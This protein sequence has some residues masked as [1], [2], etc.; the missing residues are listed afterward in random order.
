MNLGLFG[1]SGCVYE[2]GE[3]SGCGAGG[4]LGSGWEKDDSGANCWRIGTL[5]I[6]P[7]VAGCEDDEVHC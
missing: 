5:D 2:N 4:G 6:D 3:T 1:E 7:V